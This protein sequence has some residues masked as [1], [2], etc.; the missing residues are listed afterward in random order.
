MLPSSE[1]TVQH[2]RRQQLSCGG[3]VF[4]GFEEA[5]VQLGYLEVT[6]QEKFRSGWLGPF[7]EIEGCCD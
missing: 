1:C 4:F 3:V 6:V 5:Q 2:L 7:V